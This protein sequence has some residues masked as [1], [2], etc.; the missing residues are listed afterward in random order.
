MNELEHEILER[1]L[2]SK[3]RKYWSPNEIC[4]WNMNIRG[5]TV[6][7]YEEAFK[8]LAALFPFIK[9]AKGLDL[10]KCWHGKGEGWYYIDVKRLYEAWLG[11]MAKAVEE[12]PIERE[13][14]FDYV[15]CLVAAGVI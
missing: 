14:E 5:R 4:D 7:Q 15:A 2:T 8:N 11:T 3:A 10:A 1:M 6:E 12:K 9:N 13:T